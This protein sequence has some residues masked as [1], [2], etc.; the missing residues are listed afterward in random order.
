MLKYSLI[1]AAEHVPGSILKKG[2]KASTVWMLDQ[3]TTFGITLGV[4][5]M[6]TLVRM[7][8]LK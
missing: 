3:G 2:L 8:K 5:E 4:M 6:E 1:G 7:K